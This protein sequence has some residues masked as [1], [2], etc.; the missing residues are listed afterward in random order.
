MRFLSMYLF[1][2]TAP[3]SFQQ[4]TVKG[5]RGRES[6]LPPTEEEFCLTRT[7]YPSKIDTKSDFQ[8]S[9]DA[10]TTYDT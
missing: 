10:H 3:S 1:G 2:S 8:P 4:L 9:R 7:E 6:V 5:Q